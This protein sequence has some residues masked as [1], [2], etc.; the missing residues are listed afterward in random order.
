MLQ[1]VSIYNKVSDSYLITHYKTVSKIIMG[2][3][4]LQFH[5]LI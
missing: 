2:H 4:T 3:G 5:R 1:A